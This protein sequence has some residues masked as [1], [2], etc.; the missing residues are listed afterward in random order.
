[1]RQGHTPLGYRIEHGNALIDEIDAAAVRK[2]FENYLS[3]MSLMEAAKAAGINC[4][5]GSAAKILGNKRYLGDNYYPPLIDKD[6]F[7][8]A[9]E[10]RERR[11]KQLGRTNLTGKSKVKCASTQFSMRK[12]NEK[13][14]NPFRQA[15]YAYSLIKSE[16]L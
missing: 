14:E 9:K 16:V 5:H 8:R 4:Y 13:Y 1:M 15:E 11:A 2:L 6:L 10:E 12:P 3:G 7:D